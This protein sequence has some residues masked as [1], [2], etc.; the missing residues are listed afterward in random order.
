MYR[1]LSASLQYQNLY[2]K[3]VIDLMQALAFTANRG[4]LQ[5]PMQGTVLTAS[6]GTAPL[7]NHP[8]MEEVRPVFSPTLAQAQ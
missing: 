3:P 8:V 7:G 2:L 6:N 5:P 4:L 1:W